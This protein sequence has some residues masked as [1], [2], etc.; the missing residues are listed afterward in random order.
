MYFDI[1][2]NLRYQLSGHVVL[3]SERYHK[4]GLIQRVVLDIDIFWISDT[5][6]DIYMN[7]QT[8]RQMF[9]HW[10]R[11]FDLSQDLCSI[12]NLNSPSL[13]LM[14]KKYEKQAIF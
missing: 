9:L 4:N 12:V 2:S 14:Q 10:K 5:K 6:I 7:R 1:E 13:Q 11:I 8:A 3:N